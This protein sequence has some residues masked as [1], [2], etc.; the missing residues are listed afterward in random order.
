MNHD[1]NYAEIA[2]LDFARIIYERCDRE[3]LAANGVQD[4]PRCEVMLRDASDQTGEYAQ[5]CNMSGAS[6]VDGV[7]M[8]ES[9]R[10]E[11]T[12]G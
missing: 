1:D 5:A 9:C 2:E 3:D 6:P 11:Q 8:C 10:K 4:W 12:N 7:M